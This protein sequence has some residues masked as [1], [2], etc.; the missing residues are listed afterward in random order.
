MPQAQAEPGKA[1]ATDPLAGAILAGRVLLATLFLIFGFDKLSHYSAA[2]GY[3]VQTGA[4]LPP[5]AAVIAIVAELGLSVT[6]ILG[7]F[8]RPLAVLLAVYTFGTALIGHHFWTMTGLDRYL[9]E[10]NFY[11]NVSIIGGLIL[12]AVTGAGRYSVDAKIG[13]A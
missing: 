5:V 2:V 9:N 12:L 8:T 7:V 3:M 11:K 4:P 6:L 10:I 1:A 13:R